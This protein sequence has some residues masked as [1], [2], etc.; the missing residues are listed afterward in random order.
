MQNS[1]P[2]APFEMQIQGAHKGG[3]SRGSDAAKSWRCTHI[4]LKYE[5]HHLCPFNL[6]FSIKLMLCFGCFEGFVV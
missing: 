5:R 2:G 4:S 6:L 1:V 3:V